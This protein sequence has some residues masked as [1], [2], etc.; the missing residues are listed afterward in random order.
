M[1][2]LSWLISSSIAIFG[3]MLIQYFY[4]F[5]SETGNLGIV[6]IAIVLPFVLLCLFITFRYFRSASKAMSDKIMLICYNIFGIA[7]ATAFIYFAIDYRNEVFQTLGGG[8]SS[9]NSTIYGEFGLNSDTS[10]VYFNFYTISATI[11]V[12]AVISSLSSFWL[13]VK[14]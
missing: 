12:T 7:L 14:K 1:Q 13:N 10:N 9:P 8:A 4:Q 5:K 11:T 2:R 6:G 3:V